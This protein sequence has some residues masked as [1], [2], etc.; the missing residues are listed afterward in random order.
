MIMKMYRQ[1]GITGQVRK[2]NKN[3]PF[4]RFKDVFYIVMTIFLIL[5]SSFVIEDVYSGCGSVDHDR[6]GISDVYSIAVGMEPEMLTINN[7]E[8][9]SEDKT[10]E[11]KTDDGTTIVI[12]EYTLG[13]KNEEI[14][15]YQQILYSLGFLIS[16][17]SSELTEEVQ[18]AIKTYQ[19]MKGLSKP[20]SWIAPPLSLWLPKT[21]NLKKATAEKCCKPISRF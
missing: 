19:A 16:Q 2:M 4:K 10:T 8:A 20:G 15:E 17:P 11:I 7:G 13:D 1:F 12:T 6:K 3:T 14:L 21:L 5:T 9:E 18:T